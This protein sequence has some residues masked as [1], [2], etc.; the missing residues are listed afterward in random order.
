MPIT[1]VM[2][3]RSW[4]QRIFIWVITAALTFFGATMAIP[5]LITLTSSTTNPYDYDRFSIL[6]KS[7]WSEEDRLMKTLPGFL[8][9]FPGW[10][11][12]LQYH[13]P[14]APTRWTSWRTIGLDGEGVARLVRPLLETAPDEVAR[15]RLR[16]ADYADFSLAHPLEDCRVTLTREKASDFI[17]AHYAG[18]WEQTHPDASRAAREQGALEALSQ[19]WRMPIESTIAISFEGEMRRPM[20]QQ[21]FA[22]QDNPKS[23]DF[24]VLADAV[25]HGFGVPGVSAG[26]KTFLRGKGLDEERIAALNPLPRTA[27]AE[28]KEWWRT[29]ARD[30]A[31]ASPVVPFPMAV[32]WREFL[33][34]DAVRRT[35]GMKEGEFFTV[36][37][38][39]RLAGTAYASLSQT[40]FPLPSRGFEALRPLWD[41]FVRERYPLR[42][43]TIEASPEM[44]GRY[45]TFLRE[46]YKTVAA[47]NRLLR[48]QA[49]VWADFPVRSEMP[50]NAADATAGEREVWMDFVKSLPAED[51]RVRSSES[52][53][54][55]FLRSRYGSVEEVNRV[56]GWTLSCLEEARPPFADAWVETWR[57]HQSAFSWAPFLENYGTIAR[58]LVRQGNALPVTFWLIFL[59]VGATLTINPLAAYALSRFNLRAKDKILLFCLATAAFPA[60]VSAIPGYLLMR[61]LGLLNTFFALVLPGAA[62]GMAIFILKGFYD[63]LPQE[64]FEAATIDGAKEWQIFLFVTLPMVKPIMAINAL[65]A[66]MHA[67]SSWEWALIICQRKDMWTLSVWLYQASQWWADQPWIT[68]AGFVIASIPTLLVF[69]FCQKIIMRG[70]IVPS[71]K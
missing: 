60:M 40:P 38:Y 1:T 32:S 23:R 52:A 31:P 15:R 20:A 66:F 28:E 12:V 3:R 6:P 27:S 10:H 5:F 7:L 18:V 48:T 43:T 24:L 8:A 62:N 37:T 69:L 57:R 30:Q 61:D 29:F 54:Q 50:E 33:S 41:L 4:S 13:F 14:E 67:Y 34:S 55:D 49:S 58:F 17:T 56:Y 44:Q 2:G 46:R 70:I 63:S 19:A 35:L 11:E 26:W 51:R 47:L 65:N 16:A 25:R 59:S 45:E 71:M 39:N 42:L 64:L 53:Y 9:D 68:T 22:P 21:S 36:A